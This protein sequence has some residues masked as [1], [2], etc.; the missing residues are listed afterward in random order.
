MAF[1]KPMKSFVK[2]QKVGKGQQKGQQKGQWQLVQQHAVV[3][4]RKGGKGQQKGQQSWEQRGK[5]GKQKVQQK[6]QQKVEQQIKQ[7]GHQQVVS[8][9]KGKG[10]WVQIAAPLKTKKPQAKTSFKVLNTKFLKNRKGGPKGA[11]KGKNV[12]TGGNANAPPED[13]LKEKL[14]GID[15]S[16]KVWVGGLGDGEDWKSLQTHFAN[17]AKPWIANIMHKGQACLAYK[18]AEQV[19][20]VINGMNGSELNGQTL[21]VDVWTEKASTG[22][23]QKKGKGGKNGKGVQKGKG[24]GVKGAKPAQGKKQVL[25]T[26]FVKP[27]P[28]KKGAGKG[29]GK[30]AAKTSKE[31]DPIR[32]KLA[33]V[34]P[35]L[36][37]WVG[38]LPDGCDW[39]TLKEVFATVAKPSIVHVGKK[40][41]AT[42]TFKKS[43][44]VAKAVEALNGCDFS[45][46]PIQVDV[47]SKSERA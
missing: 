10:K 46:T 24:K 44:D 47:W 14:A 2:G 32:E 33:E 8:K 4:S 5:Q 18:T 35:S 16:L 30:Q 45:G 20:N 13:K 42:V 17:V 22:K 23:G 27:V 11:G 36:K 7:Q 41:Q 38:G 34:D 6:V 15:A 12:V 39:K 19:A 37:V 25:Q 9:G 29:T 43:G 3:K 31:V 28:K 40:G 1:G 21:E 26:K